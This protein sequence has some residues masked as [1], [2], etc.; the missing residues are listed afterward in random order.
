MTLAAADLSFAYAN[1]PV[2]QR[3]S[4]EFQPGRVTAV[5]GPN[6]AGKST[7]LRL[8]LGLLKP[9]SGAATLDGLSVSAIPAPARAR[10][11]AFVPQRPDAAFGFTVAQTVAF[12]RHALGPDPTAVAR[13][14]THVELAD[15]AHEPFA[16][17]SVGQQQRAALARTLAQLDTPAK[18][19]TPAARYL[20]ADEPIS[21]MDPRHA[22]QALALMRT[23]AHDHA[24]GVV[25]VLH[26]LTAARAHADEAL[27]LDPAGQ[28]AA[29]GPAQSVLTPTTLEPVFQTPFLELQHP[30][31]PTPALIPK[32]IAH[33]P[34]PFAPPAS[35]PSTLS[36]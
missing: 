25:V 34:L 26:D 21:A 11:L 27:L 19:N 30:D 1:T 18:A 31:L 28:P 32:P 35:P 22:A 14:L 3:V 24:I 4:A 13:A 7:L 10:R 20:I 23:L 33:G 9:D 16:H 6:G 12:A 8:L 17:L 15:R 29:K 5:I 2:L 36:P